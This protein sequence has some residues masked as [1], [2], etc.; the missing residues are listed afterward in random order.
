M[1]P[2]EFFSYEDSDVFGISV[3]T[4]KFNRELIADIRRGPVSDYGD[5]EVAV[6]LARLHDELEKYGTS[7]DPARRPQHRPVSTDGGLLCAS[8]RDRRC[9]PR[10]GRR[11]GSRS[12][13]EASRNIRSAG[14]SWA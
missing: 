8:F 6:A 3:S 10:L 14:R 7:G 2:E 4:P 5:V 1:R 9:P 11:S 13:R 12:A